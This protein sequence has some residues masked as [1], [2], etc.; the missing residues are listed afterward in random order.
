MDLTPYVE[1]LRNQV[2]AATEL[3]G[4]DVRA[5]ADRLMAPVEAATRLVLLDVLSDA[6]DEIT[7]ELAPG[8]VEVRLRRGDPEFVVTSAPDLGVPTAAP[9][10]G[11]LPPP[12]PA[13]ADTDESATARITLRIPE[14][15][16]VR[17]EQAA[18]EAGLS[19]NAWLV[20]VTTDA[21]GDPPRSRPSTRG[22]TGD[23]V[24]G[25]VR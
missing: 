3:G 1:D 8:S 13:G 16:K 25:W 14:P 18:A 24:T 11:S 4:D 7:G 5:L 10:P 21:L 20:R 22:T 17:I 23:H 2:R 6:A 12:P 9:A 19:V 15:T